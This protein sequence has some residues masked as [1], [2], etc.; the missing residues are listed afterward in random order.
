MHPNE[1]EPEQGRRPNEI[2]PDEIWRQIERIS[3]SKGFARSERLRRFLRHIVSLTLEG[4]QDELKEYGV[5]VEVFDRGA[6]FDPRLDSI[7]RS[8]A[9]RLR[10]RLQEYYDTEGRSDPLNIR[11]PA[12]A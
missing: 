6:S 4:C 10:T 3:A 8:E 11:I 5:A 7:V 1:R 2:G 12:G 9:R